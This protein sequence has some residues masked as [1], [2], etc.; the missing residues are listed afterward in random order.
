[1]ASSKCLPCVRDCSVLAEYR[2]LSTGGHLRRA[3]DGFHAVLQSQSISL[4]SFVAAI[5]VAT[6]LALFLKET[7]SA[8]QKVH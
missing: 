6:I 8:A 2:D 1:M 5:V 3:G 4:R 7:G